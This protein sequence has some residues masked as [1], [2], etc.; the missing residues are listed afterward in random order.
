VTGDTI[1]GHFWDFGD[2][3]TDTSAIPLHRYTVAGQ[4]TVTLIAYSPSS[5]PSAPVQHLINVIQAPTPLY[6]ATIACLGVPTVFTNLSSVPGGESID[7]TL[8]DFTGGNTS[9]VYNPSYLFN[10]PGYFNVQLE[11]VSSSGCRADTVI[12]VKVSSLPVPD[13]SF[14][15]TCSSQSVQF[16]NLSTN[17]T[18]ATLSSYSW[19]FG[20]PASGTLNSSNQINPTHV[21]ATSG[22]YTVGLTAV[23]NYGCS[24]TYNRIVN[25]RQSP[26]ARF[27]YSPTCF[28]DLMLFYNTGSSSV[29]SA[30]LW[31]FGDF[32]GNQLRDPA[33]YYAVVGNYTVTLTVYAANGCVATAS[34]LVTVSPIPT[35]NFTAPDACLGTPLQLLDNS[36]ISPGSISSRKWYVDTQLF[37]TVSVNPFVTFDS[38]ITYQVKLEVKSDIGCVN[39]IVK[40]ITVNPLPQANFSF[41]PQFGNP[42]LDVS[43]TNLSS[44]ATTYEWNFGD[45]STGSSLPAP[46][47]LYTDTGIFMIEQIAISSYGCRDTVNKN[48]YVIRP[49]LDIAVTGDSSYFDGTYFHVVA[50]LSNL[51]TREITSLKMIASLDNGNEIKEDLTQIIPNGS[52]GQISYAFRAAFPLTSADRLQYY[53]IRAADPNNE[54]DDQPSNNEKCFSRTKE[55]VGIEVFPNPFADQVQIRLIIP[56]PEE[57]FVALYDETGHQVNVFYDAEAEPG[58]LQ[59]NPDVTQLRNGVYNLEV[60]FKE[61]ILYRHLIKINNRK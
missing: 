43:F 12:P 17:D 60:R 35:A 39:T 29:D 22:N 2:G 32:Q 16:T 57:L 26:V 11:I 41:T 53:C 24:S 10:S 45:N 61:D 36:T 3:Y 23:N 47:H 33:H 30:Y 4:Y 46:Q 58:L 52:G 13:Y 6:T 55:S 48:I 56:Y 14:V 54:T 25:I 51:G 49:V 50:R 1:S 20:D 38:V 8:W 34:R 15:N 5:C 27:T 9:S 59:L 44:G 31:N 28:G 37:D 21:F 40:P 7:S 18:L 42:P 19:T